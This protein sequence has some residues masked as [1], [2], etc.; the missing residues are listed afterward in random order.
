MQMNLILNDRASHAGIGGAIASIAD[1]ENRVVDGG[2][3][4]QNIFF[5][6]ERHAHGSDD[7]RCRIASMTVAR[8]NLSGLFADD[9]VSGGLC[10][11]SQI[12]ARDS[13]AESVGDKNLRVAAVLF[14]RKIPRPIEK[15]ALVNA[16][17]G[18]RSCRLQAGRPR[19]V[20]LLRV[21]SPQWHLPEPSRLGRFP[22][23]T[24]PLG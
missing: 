21:R 1:G 11:D 13:S 14:N 22:T 3:D 8:G 19:R 4:V 9:F 7:E 18:F 16:F 10:G 2:G 17:T 24:K 12:E 20:L 15:R 23:S 6:I 5:F